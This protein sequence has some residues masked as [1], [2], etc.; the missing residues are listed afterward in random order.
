MGIA[1]QKAVYRVCRFLVWLFYPHM[2]V[3]GV[4]NLPDEP[5]VA[6]GNHAQMNG[7][8]SSV[9]YYPRPGRTWCAGQM[10]HLREVPAYAYQDFWSGKPG[11]IRW[12]YKVLSYLIAP[13]CVCIFNHAPTIGVYRDGR[14]I[15]TFKQTVNALKSGEDVVIF[16]EC[17][18]EH[19]HIVHAFQENFT[20]VAKLYYKQTGKAL[21]FVPIYIC[22]AL[23]KIV[24]GKPVYY[25]PTIPIA[26]Q[27]HDLCVQLMDSITALAESLPE[28]RV[29][30]YPN[31]PKSKYPSSRGGKRQQP[32]R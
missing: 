29:V 15:N 9:L 19:N 2:T 26:T 8:I 30:P 21:P 27:R 14:I 10:M 25:D 4:E 17:Y 12:F 28:H 20:D 31:L 1:I 18:D 16:P 3:E 6:V 32:D 13:L 11:Y 24:I 7:P 23:K 5:V 22:P